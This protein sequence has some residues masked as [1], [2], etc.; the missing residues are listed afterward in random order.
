MSANHPIW[1]HIWPLGL[2]QFSDKIVVK[3]WN[4]VRI[5]A[6]DWFS[7]HGVGGHILKAQRNCDNERKRLKMKKLKN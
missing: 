6:P 1:T 5:P 4:R 3:H 7:R 2:S